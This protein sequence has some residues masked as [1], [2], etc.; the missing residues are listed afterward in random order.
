MPVLYSQKMK[1]GKTI[2]SRSLIAD[3]KEILACMF[4]SGSLITGLGLNYL[5]EFW[6]ADPAAGILIVYFLVKEGYETFSGDDD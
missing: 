2:E 5:F 3:A 6:W 4:L 1:I